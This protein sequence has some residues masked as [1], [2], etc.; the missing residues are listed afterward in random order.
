VD[1][2]ARRQQSLNEVN[3]F[4]AS[5]LGRRALKDAHISPEQVTKAVSSLDD[6]ELAKLAART[7]RAQQDFAAGSL[8][9]HA[10]VIIVVA[11]AVVLVVIL[12]TKL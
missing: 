2:S 9:S 4:F 12:A 5:S 8:S 10:L 6:A 7:Q 1:S 11:I 3:A